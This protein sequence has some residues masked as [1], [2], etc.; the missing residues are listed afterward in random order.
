MP[1]IALSEILWQNTCITINYKPIFFKDFRAKGINHVFH[2]FDSNGVLYKWSVFQDKYNLPNSLFM[3]WYQLCH[4]IPNEWK[5]MI[6]I[7]G[8]RYIQNVFLEQHF[9]FGCRM[10]SLGM[11]DAKT[12]YSNQIKKLFKAPTSQS[13]LN[14][15]FNQE[16]EW[17]NIYLLA[18]KVTLDT[19][20]R[21][22][23]YKIV[24]NI[25]FLNQQLFKSG[26]SKTD[27]CTYCA[28]SVENI[29]HLFSQCIVTKSL[30]SKIQNFFISKVCIPNLSIQ[31][32][33]IGFA[34]LHNDNYIF[35]NHLLLIFKIYVYR[36]RNHNVLNITSFIQKVASV[37]SLERFSIDHNKHKAVFHSKKWS[38]VL[39]LLM[40]VSSS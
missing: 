6:K 35:I 36:K 8:G 17:Q 16:L 30:W 20:T 18:R 4:A 25:L 26:K 12:L 9:T 40:L 39:P 33:F 15:L 11:L 32:A 1:S 10:L 19:Y 37:E 28:S 29:Q 7:D 13:S 2:L 31:S 34:D 23:H 38:L 27:K 22:F 21:V 3:K 14:T 24:N 5:S